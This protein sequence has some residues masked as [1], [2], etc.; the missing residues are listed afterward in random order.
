MSLLPNLRITEWTISESETIL[1][2]D[3][4]VFLRRE[5]PVF[6]KGRKTYSDFVHPDTGEIIVKVTYSDTFDSGGYLN[7]ISRVIEWYNQDGTVGLSKTVLQPLNKA[8]AENEKRERRVRA[9]DY[10]K[11]AG[12]GTPV[13]PYMIAVFLHYEQVVRLWYDMGGNGVAEAVQNETDPTILAYLSIETEPD[14]T[15]AQGII[16]QTDHPWA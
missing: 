12:K 5:S 13:E 1:A 15:V 7:G 9:I 2:T 4:T 16:Y 3:Y 11:A 6:T 14:W 10:L 8:E